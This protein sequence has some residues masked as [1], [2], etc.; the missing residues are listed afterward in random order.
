M[1]C[2]KYVCSIFLRARRIQR[3]FWPVWSDQAILSGT[4]FPPITPALWTLQAVTRTVG[5]TVCACH[6]HSCGSSHENSL[7]GWVNQIR[8]QKIPYNSSP[9]SPGSV[10]PSRPWSVLACPLIT[11]PLL[12]NSHSQVGTRFFGSLGI[13]DTY[14]NSSLPPPPSRM[15]IAHSSSCILW[16][17]Q[18]V[19]M[20]FISPFTPSRSPP[21]GWCRYRI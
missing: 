21:K 16:A 1:L 15:L 19:V 12:Y 17:N 20:L 7:L 9:S 14:D 2:R 18:T 4:A 13:S 5:S 3:G 6:P 10:V 11:T 8:S